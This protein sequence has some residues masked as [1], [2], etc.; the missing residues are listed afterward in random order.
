MERNLPYQIKGI[1]RKEKKIGNDTFNGDALEFTLYYIRMLLY[2][3]FCQT[4]YWN[5]QPQVNKKKVQEIEG[6]N[7]TISSN[8]IIKIGTLEKSTNKLLE[9]L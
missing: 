2:P 6:R 3:Y 5:F 4:V 9:F 7:K 1:Y 8:D